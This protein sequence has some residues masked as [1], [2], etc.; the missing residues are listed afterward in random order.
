MHLHRC[1]FCLLQMTIKAHAKTT[2]LILVYVVLCSQSTSGYGPSEF[3]MGREPAPSFIS[4]EKSAITFSLQFHNILQA[5]ILIFRFG[6][7]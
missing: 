4:E 6:F 3:K 1:W 7:P 5:L 2:Q